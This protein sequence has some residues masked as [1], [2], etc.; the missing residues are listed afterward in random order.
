MTAPIL[1]GFEY[2]RPQSSKTTSRSLEPKWD[3]Y[4]WPGI[5]ND[6]PRVSNSRKTYDIYSLG[7]VLLEIAHW[8]PLHR[9]LGLKRWPEPSSQDAR[10]R[11]W[12]LEEERFPP[13]KHSNPLVELR[14]ITGEKYWRAV[15][16]CLVAH[17][18]SGMR[19]PEESDQSRSAEIGLQLQKAF[20]ELVVEE[21]KSI[22]I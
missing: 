15:R 16:R 11:A 5:Q 3:I 7:L 8:Q 4:R 19:V 12:L 17:G 18:E 1:S 22:S 14:N 2:A 10:I 21:L 9:I 13:F 6:V 20:T